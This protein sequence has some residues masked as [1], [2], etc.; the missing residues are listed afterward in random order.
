MES[1]APGGRGGA[2]AIGTLL[3]VSS[4]GAGSGAAASRTDAGSVTAS[5]VVDHR[6][7]DASSAGAGRRPPPAPGRGGISGISLGSDALYLHTEARLAARLQGGRLVLAF[8]RHNPGAREIA[9]EVASLVA[10]CSAEEWPLAGP[11]DGRVV[12]LLLLDATTFGGD[13]GE[14]L[15][16]DVRQWCAQVAASREPPQEECSSFSSSLGGSSRRSGGGRAASPTR[17]NSLSRRPSLSRLPG[18]S[19]ARGPVE[20]PLLLHAALAEE[21]R[22]CSVRRGIPRAAHQLKTAVRRAAAPSRR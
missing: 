15:A 6:S 5:G 12:P 11:L 4:A 14:D 19:C 22:G 7:L 2:V 9:L 10:G 13:C 20:P 21:T 17:R 3:G 1:G 16:D 8:S 18:L